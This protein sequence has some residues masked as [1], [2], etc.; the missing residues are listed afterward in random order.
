[1]ATPRGRVKPGGVI[2]VVLMVAGILGL[3]YVVESPTFVRPEPVTPTFAEDASIDYAPFARV[4]VQYVD[5][6]GLVDYAALKAAPDDLLAFL[7]Q[8]AEISPRNHP[9]AFRTEREALAYWLNAHNAY[10]LKT[11]LDAYPVKSVQDIPA[12]PDVH[13]ATVCVCGGE[14]LSLDDIEYGIIGTE[15]PDPRVQF[16]LS[17][18]TMGCPW[19]PTEAFVPVRLEEQ[20]DRARDH[21]SKSM[22]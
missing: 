15:F 14:E 18:A 17:C 2:V 6:Y 7:E 9:E 3:A 16:A 5:S 19:L 4:C 12:E 21:T 8:V 1:M 10:M 22:I 11:V 20:L 13:S